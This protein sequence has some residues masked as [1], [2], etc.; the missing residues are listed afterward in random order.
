QPLTTA[1]SIFLSH[2]AL[3]LL[4]SS[5]AAPIAARRFC[6]KRSS[7]SALNFLLTL[8]ALAA[9]AWGSAL[10]GFN[11]P[12]TWMF[13]IFFAEWEFLRFFFYVGLPVAL[14]TGFVSFLTDNPST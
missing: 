13:G 3:L 11:P 5:L 10:I 12:G 8:S 9:F 1:M 4:I 6:K 7:R 14:A 2:Y